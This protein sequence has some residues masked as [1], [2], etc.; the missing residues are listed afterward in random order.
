MSCSQLFIVGRG[1]SMT[2]PTFL[3]FALVY[4]LTSYKPGICFVC[5]Y[6]G[7]L[8]GLVGGLPCLFF[9]RVSTCLVLVLLFCHFVILLFCCFVTICW[10]TIETCVGVP[11]PT[12]WSGGVHCMV[13]HYDFRLVV[14]CCWSIDW[15]PMGSSSSDAAMTRIYIYIRLT[16]Y[17][18]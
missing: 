2:G 10:R 16:H 11:P 1:D 3:C 4:I 5:A 8:C 9:C 13:D 6:R 14:F 18:P 17:S 7:L 12:A 15:L